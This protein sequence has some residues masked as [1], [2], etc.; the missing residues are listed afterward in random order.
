MPKRASDNSLEFIAKKLRQLEKEVKRSRQKKRNNISL[1]SSSSSSCP[2][3]CSSRVP[4]PNPEW[5]ETIAN[6]VPRV[7]TI[8][9]EPST[10]Q[11][12]EIPLIEI[13]DNSQDDTRPSCSHEEP[14]D[15]IN[16]ELLDILGAD[17]SVT[18]EYGPDINK[19]VASRF[20]HIATSGLSREVRKNLLMKNLV[21]QN[22]K[23]IA[24]P[25]LNA[26][27]KAA[28]S[29]QVVKRDR[30]IEARQ[31]QMAAAISSLGIIISNQLGPKDKNNE[32]IKDLMDV[33]RMFCDIQHTESEARRNFA[34]YS[35]K[36][37]LKDQLSITKIDK[38][39]F[40]NDLAETLKT[41]KAVSKSISDLKQD[42][43]KK[44]KPAASTKH[45]NW[46]A[47]TSARRQPTGPSPRYQ[48][49][50]THNAQHRAPLSQ[51]YAQRF[52]QTR[53]P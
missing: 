44:P 46:K 19:D 37:E 32:L 23:N 43:P 30:A 48:P 4:S 28:L 51:N 21:P 38:Y 2:S 3:S 14:S 8:D 47:R 29:E 17:P 16:T 27:I 33:G 13:N 5:Q 25:Q 53:R 18:I 22:C 26:E 6:T 34:L 45:L 52:K 7:E 35:V 41:A 12:N 50:A 10:A 49:P 42:A 31:K 15:D 1:S 40:G 9:V 11:N 36:K 24:A 20:A 39:L